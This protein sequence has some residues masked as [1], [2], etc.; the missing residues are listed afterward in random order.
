MVFVLCTCWSKRAQNTGSGSSITTTRSNSHTSSMNVF[1]RRKQTKIYQLWKEH[2]RI[3]IRSLNVNVCIGCRSHRPTCTN[4]FS[5]V[6]LRVRSHLCTR[7]KYQPYMI[8]QSKTS[9]Y[10]TGRR[11]IS[12]SLVHTLLQ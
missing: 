10:T 1:C 4:R 5:I 8:I 2:N 6:W 9:V 7:T 3:I 11:L 12:V